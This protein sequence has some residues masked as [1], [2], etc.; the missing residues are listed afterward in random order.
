MTAVPKI[1]LLRD[2]RY[3]LEYA[4]LRILVGFVRLFPVD[5]GGSISAAAW[6]FLGKR[7]RRHKRALIES[8]AGVPGEDG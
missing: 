7:N 1:P 6:R 3:R 4:G 8:G 5:L 2:L